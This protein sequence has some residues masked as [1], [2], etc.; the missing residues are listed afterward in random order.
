MSFIGKAKHKLQ[1]AAGKAEQ[2]AGEVTGNEELTAEGLGDQA[3]AEVKQADD[4][5]EDATGERGQRR[6]VS[7]GGSPHRFR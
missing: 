3:R 6:S 5:A 1:E 4:R 2:V 7:D